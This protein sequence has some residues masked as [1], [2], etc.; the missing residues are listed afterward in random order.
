LEKNILD[1]LND[2]VT[3][4]DVRYGR[5]LEND[6]D[7]ESAKLMKFDQQIVVHEARE[8]EVMAQTR[9]NVALSLPFDHPR[10][11]LTDSLEAL[12]E[13]D[14][15]VESATQFARDHRLDLAIAKLNVEKSEKNVAFQRTQL[16]QKVG[17]GP[18]YE[19]DF[20]DEN[21]YGPGLS[22]ELP[23]FD[24]NQAQIAKAEYR[25]RQTRKELESLELT[26]SRE[27]TDTLALLDFLRAK[28]RVM[29]D[30]IMP[31]LDRKVAYAEKWSHAH[32]LNLINLIMAQEARLRHRTMY[33]E[34]LRDYRHAQVTLHQALWG[35]SMN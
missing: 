27:I 13:S 18:I 24:Q 1:T 3:R 14:W 9:L 35:G 33:L 2:L 29:R 15:T 31:S 23:I 30:D 28:I 19:G 11:A 22:V 34:S 21:T 16:F 5:G 7:M 4:M 8:M 12:P 32:Q 25:L 26:A 17:L 10:F 20:D 6:L